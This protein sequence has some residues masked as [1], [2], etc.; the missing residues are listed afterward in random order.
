[1]SWPTE[2]KKRT[3]S[4]N[5]I[6]SLFVVF[7]VVVVVEEEEGAENDTKISREFVIA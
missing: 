5:L 7:V 3:T 4:F 1:M 2:V 6:F